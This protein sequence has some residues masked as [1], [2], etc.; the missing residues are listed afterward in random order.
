MPDYARPSNINS[1]RSRTYRD[2]S[3]KRNT[4]RGLP[5][6]GGTAPAPPRDT[7]TKPQFRLSNVQPSQGTPDDH[8]LNF[9]RALKNGEDLGVAVPVGSING[10]AQRTAAV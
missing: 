5:L 2:D 1:A 10:L 7:P 3:D 9:A 4:R 8:P 6:C